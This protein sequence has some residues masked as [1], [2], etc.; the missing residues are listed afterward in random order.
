M[1]ALL[2]MVGMT[3]PFVAFF[4]FFAINGAVLAVRWLCG[5]VRGSDQ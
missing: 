2:F 3:I 5:V 1:S 4:A